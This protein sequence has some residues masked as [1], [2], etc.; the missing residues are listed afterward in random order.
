MTTAMTTS[1]LQLV[2]PVRSTSTPAILLQGLTKSFGSVRALR[3]VNLTVQSGS[4]VGILG[5]NGAGKTT[6]VRILTTLLRP[7]AGR[8]LI[9]GRDVVR[10][11][12]AVRRLI[13]L[14]GQSTA[15]E[16]EL[17]G[18]ENLQFI[19]RLHHLSRSQA[20]RRSAQLIEEFDLGDFADRPSKTLS[21]G[22][23]R[24]LDLAVSL[25]GEPEVLFLD[26]PTVGLDPRAR[27][28]MWDTVRG[29]VACG[30]T[31]LLT[32][33]NMDE[34]DEL[35]DEIVVFDHGRVIASG[36][37]AELK[38]RVGGDV[39]ELELAD[40]SRLA[41]A[42]WAL[43]RSGIGDPHI[44]ADTGTVTIRVGSQG[45]RA[46]VEAIRT[47]DA[48]GI[49]LHDPRLRRPSLDDVFLALT[50]RAT[51]GEPELEPAGSGGSRDR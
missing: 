25:V 11:G 20:R 48:A 38:G 47:L 50:G 12:P 29:L 31:L 27:R 18:R 17:T 24:R 22:M 7:D 51:T 28:S 44:D 26:E 43:A 19:A 8:A 23:R 40:P 34:A 49:G 30:T 4:V 15:I 41:D 3:S 5:P 2:E 32:T 42:R 37:P 13:G 1:G 9:K 6:T 45:S 21:G 36:T 46:L 33:Q 14:A 39:L 10:E 16:D 35:A